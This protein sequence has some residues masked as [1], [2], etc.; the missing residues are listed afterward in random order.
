MTVQGEK[1]KEKRRKAR[2]RKGSVKQIQKNL[3]SEKAKYKTFNAMLKEKR[4]RKIKQRDDK[5]L[6][7]YK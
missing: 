2:W 3:G 6:K 4:N 1:K 7:R 5:T